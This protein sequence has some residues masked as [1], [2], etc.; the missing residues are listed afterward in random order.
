[1][2]T[3]IFC[4]KKKKFERLENLFH[5]KLKPQ[6]ETTETIKITIFLNIY[7]EMQFKQL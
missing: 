5:T 7:A 1:M 6:Q 3:L 2:N 4:A